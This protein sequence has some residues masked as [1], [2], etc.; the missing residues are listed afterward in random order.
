MWAGLW[1][2]PPPGIGVRPGG[3][4]EPLPGFLD[5]ACPGAQ[6]EGA[7]VRL[8]R[9][10]ALVSALAAGVLGA[11]DDLGPGSGVFP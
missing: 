11:P 6:M 1:L 10:G 3:R 4:P 2:H 9:G 7:T 5:G 8:L